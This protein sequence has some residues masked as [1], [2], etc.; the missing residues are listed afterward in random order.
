MY[1]PTLDPV[2][3]LLPRNLTIPWALQPG[4]T[5]GALALVLAI[6]T[7]C[8]RHSGIAT[9]TRPGRRVY[10]ATTRPKDRTPSST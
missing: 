8:V 2:T 4:M 7:G 6:L 5:F 10:R 9:A 3:R 1:S